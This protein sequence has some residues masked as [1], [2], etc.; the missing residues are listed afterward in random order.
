MPV[1]R[2]EFSFSPITSDVAVERVAGIDRREELHAGVAEIGDRIERDVRHGLAEHDVEHQQIVDR[3][4]R[5][6]DRLGEGVG[7]LHREARAEQ[8]VVERDVARRDG[9][10]RRVADGLAEAEILEEIA[11]AGLG[12]GP[13]RSNDC[14]PAPRL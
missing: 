9:A 4:A 3:R 7:R 8:P 13:V 1:L 10:R 2:L 6:A 14:I 12:H 5:I 11:G